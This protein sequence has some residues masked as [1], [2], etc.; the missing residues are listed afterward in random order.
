MSE[1][2]LRVDRL[3]A[4]FGQRV[5]LRDVSL[6]V[7]SSGIVGLLGPAGS[8]KSTLLR[9]LARLNEPL[10]SFWRRG[11]V[12]LGARE[13]LT[14][15]SSDA[16]RRQLPLLAQK[17]RLFTR[18]V[19]ENAIAEVVGERRFSREDKR[20]LALEVLARVG[21][22]E[23]LGERLDEPV[24]ALSLAEQRMLALARLVAGGARCLMADEPLRDLSEAEAEQLCEMLER[25]QRRWPLLIVTHDQGV[26]Q[27]L[28]DEVALLADGVIVEQNPREVFFETPTSS[29]ARDFRRYGNCWPKNPTP[30]SELAAIADDAFERRV[31]PGGF[32][33]ILPRQLGGTQQPGLLYDRQAEL[34]ALGRLCAVLVTLT[35]EPPDA[36]EL[37]RYGM[38]SVHFPIEDMGVPELTAAAD[39]CREIDSWLGDGKST[40][41]HCRAGLG[42]TG[43][44]LACVLVYRGENVV[45]AI[46][47]VRS[48][49]PYYIQSE[50]QLAF[51]DQLGQYLAASA[52][53]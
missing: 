28:C 42:R 30:P 21:L 27:R 46:D 37:A 20:S 2:L 16:V 39:L 53:G 50:S 45:R 36:E 32:H 19:L 51:I 25:L 40:V 47:R 5:V 35:E 8:G 22:E 41:L 23:L 15:E 14:G 4:G 38:R 18:S 10:P 11:S 43:T 12:F 3:A 29:L 33:W 13:L 6:T 52:G 26:A 48:V 17:A 7:P 31:Q 24:V 34:Q 1:P 44:M 49:N 9:A